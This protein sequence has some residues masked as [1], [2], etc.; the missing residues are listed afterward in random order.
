[1]PTGTADRNERRAD[2]NG[3]DVTG[4]EPDGGDSLS[5]SLCSWRASKLRR[6]VIEKSRILSGNMM[7]AHLYYYTGWP[8]TS[9]TWVGLT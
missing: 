1:M 8:I 6:Q 5:L 7:I 4:E 2:E 9:R 3:G